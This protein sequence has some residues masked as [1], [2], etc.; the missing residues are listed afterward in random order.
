[1]KT[2]LQN[3]TTILSMNWMVL[4]N[5]VCLIVK[6]YNNRPGLLPDSNEGDGQIAT[7]EGQCH[8]VLVLSQFTYFLAN[9]TQ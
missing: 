8:N 2:S 1:L 4:P 3:L 9:S 5:Q 7:K 6:L